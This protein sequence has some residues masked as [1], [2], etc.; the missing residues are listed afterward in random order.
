MSEVRVVGGT[1]SFL[2][3]GFSAMPVLNAN[4][5]AAV[6]FWFFC[7]KAKERLVNQLK[8]SKTLMQRNPIDF[9]YSNMSLY[10]GSLQS[11]ID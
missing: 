9:L 1:S 3:R 8:H 2:S 11:R 5:D 10:G 7:I 4:Y 6:I